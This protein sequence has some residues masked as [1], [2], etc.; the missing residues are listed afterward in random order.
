MANT[1][2]AELKC[3][4]EFQQTPWKRH[5]QA[6]QDGLLD[7]ALEHQNAR[8]GRGMRTFPPYRQ[9]LN[10]LFILRDLNPAPINSMQEFLHMGKRLGMTLGYF[11]ARNYRV[12]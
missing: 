8:T 12:F 11:T 7:I 9:E 1:I 10:S 4:V 3:P 2:M 5:L 6:L